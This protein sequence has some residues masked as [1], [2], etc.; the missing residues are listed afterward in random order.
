MHNTDL[1]FNV[2]Q[3]CSITEVNLSVCCTYNS[4]II[5]DVE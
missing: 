3:V 5:W 4:V 2:L 1:I